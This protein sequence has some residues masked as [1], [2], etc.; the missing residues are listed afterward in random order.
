M[1]ATSPPLERWNAERQLPRAATATPRASGRSPKGAPYLC[2]AILLLSVVS[3]FAVAGVPGG[4]HPPQ[5]RAGS[6]GLADSRPATSLGVSL[7]VSPHLLSY[8]IPT[9]FNSSVTNGS[10]PFTYSWSNLPPG[11]ASANAADLACTPTAGGHFDTTVSVSDSSGLTGSA[12]SEIV[13]ANGTIIAATA[14][15]TPSTASVGQSITFAGQALGGVGVYSWI[16][17]FNDGAN[18]SGQQVVHAF[19]TVGIHLAALTVTDP[20]GNVGNAT[21]VVD[22]VGGTNSS[23]VLTSMTATPAVATAPATVSFNATVSG[24]VPPYQYSWNFGDGSAGTGEAPSHLYSVAGAYVATV[25]VADASGLSVTGSVSLTIKGTVTGPLS[26]SIQASN[27]SGPSPLEVNFNAIASGG[28]VPYTYDW[29]FGD[30]SDAMGESAFHTFIATGTYLVTLYVNDSANESASSQTTILVLGSSSNSTLVAFASATPTAGAAPLTVDFSGTTTGGTGLLS[31]GWSFGDG[32]AVSGSTAV[33]TYTAQGVYQAVFQATDSSGV[34]ASASVW[35]AVNGTTT[36]SN[37]TGALAVTASATPETG[38]SPLTVDFTS[39]VSGGAAPYAYLW[40][41]GDGSASTGEAPSHV[42]W[43]IG[44]FLAT[45]TVTDA[46]GA[47]GSA[48]LTINV[49]NATCGNCTLVPAISA[50]TS[51]SA[52]E[53]VLLEA[54]LETSAA[55]TYS[56]AWS[57]GDGTSTTEEVDLA[58][59]ASEQVQVKHTYRDAGD[60]H[61]S[62]DVSGAGMAASSDTISVKVAPSTSLGPARSSGSWTE[63]DFFLVVG[64]VGA[65]VVVSAVMYSRS[66]RRPP[67]LATGVPQ[68]PSNAASGG[69]GVLDPYAAY[70]PLVLRSPLTPAPPRGGPGGA[71]PSPPSPPGPGDLV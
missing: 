33:H 46:A 29:H 47:T 51:I 69:E 11:C 53:S 39:D 20:Q 32:S 1:T 48:Y 30:G 45:L 55:G 10:T 59:H 24:G 18:A 23:L 25:K 26:V 17:N 62:V 14:S 68:G 38:P 27:S 21:V 4:A 61:V 60:Y 43:G 63:E 58:A 67:T 41:F 40:S 50:P 6:P 49:A 56:V 8:G 66:R 9:F 44:S 22:V 15:A 7:A 70:A 2:V 5:L 12:N 52:G 34:E 64:L 13:V 54:S 19:S 71:S 3:V 31:E 16:W 36:V 42:Y 65:I 37:A 28:A 35:I 57:F